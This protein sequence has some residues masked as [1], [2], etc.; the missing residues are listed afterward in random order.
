M[1][2]RMR[3]EHFTTLGQLA[4]L[5]P[6]EAA[7][8]WGSLAADMVRAARGEKRSHWNMDDD[9]VKSV[10]NERTFPEDVVYGEPLERELV[11]LSERV[12][13]RLRK[14]GLKGRTVTIKLVENWGTARSVSRTI[15]APTDSERDIGSTAVDLVRTM[16]MAPEAVRLAG[17]KVANFDEVE[18]QGSLFDER[19]GA[20]DDATPT[21]AFEGSGS[22]AEDGDVD[23]SKS[24]ALDAIREKYGY[25]SIVSGASLRSNARH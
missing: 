20:G 12:A 3:S 25:G 8:R 22:I 4:S 14:Q 24:A 11:A 18:V 23:A 16:T 7:E 21:S 10:S 15:D 9:G 1:G 6:E 5:K 19:S 13:W 17:V 2:E